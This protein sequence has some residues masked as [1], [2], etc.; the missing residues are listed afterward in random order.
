MHQNTN[1]MFTMMYGGVKAFY[2]FVKTGSLSETCN[3]KLPPDLAL[4]AACCRL[5]TEEDWFNFSNTVV[6]D[7][8]GRKGKPDR[9][10][11]PVDKEKKREARHRQADNRLARVAPN[12]PGVVSPPSYP[13]PRSSGPRFQEFA[14][15]SN[16]PD[17]RATERARLSVEHE[18]WG[19]W[20][21]YHMR[22]AVQRAAKQA[23]PDEGPG[24]AG[25]SA[26][27]PQR[28]WRGG[29]GGGSSS[30]GGWQ[31]EGWHDD[32]KRSRW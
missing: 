32:S 25:A 14:Q 9:K 16:L 3:R 31:G 17:P 28:E 13:E 6:P 30:G 7:R 1:A 29:D 22:Q 24:S 11:R 15:S 21:G 4:A 12:M 20:T 10:K 18:K 8:P 23:K 19:G 27:E 26:A 5:P 2:E